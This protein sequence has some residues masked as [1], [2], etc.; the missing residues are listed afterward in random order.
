MDLGKKLKKYLLKPLGVVLPLVLA[1][2]APMLAAGEDGLLGRYIGF[3]KD[4][5]EKTVDM[6]NLEKNLIKGALASTDKYSYFQEIET[7][8]SQVEEYE[9]A[10]FVGIGITMTQEKRGAYVNSV[11]R[12]SP[13]YRAGIK[14]GDVIVSAD[15]KEL[16]GMPIADIAKL[17][18][19]P[20][21]TTVEL[22]Y[23]IGGMGE[24]EYITVER[25]N[26]AMT[27]VEYTIIEN[28]GYI[29][30]SGF[31][32]KTGEEFAAAL[33][34]IDKA[35]TEGLILDL[36]DNGGGT[37]KGCIETAAKLLSEETIVR[38]EFKYP[39]YLDLR[40]VAPENKKSRTAVVIVNENTASAAEILAAALHDN[41][42][43]ILVGEN[44]YGKSLV[45]SSFKILDRDAYARYAAMT[46]EKDMNVIIRRLAMTG[47]TP[48]DDEWLG[49]MKLT[50]GEYMT[51]SGESI[52]NTGIRPDIEIGY[53]GT[54]MIDRPSN[55]E[56][57]VHEK[58]SVGMASPEVGKARAILKQLGYVDT[59]SD[60]YDEAA[61]NAVMKF[62]ADE[63]LYPYGV[64]DYTTQRA[65]NNRLRMM[66]AGEKDPQVAAALAQ[67]AKEADNE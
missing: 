63:G 30:I 3:I 20:L 52:N 51:P 5:S 47:N 11:F 25:A 39:G 49:A 46:G 14:A 4:K 21:D 16:A 6:V 34:K 53:E 29:R 26:V 8:E 61:F 31:T 50:V 57:W 27:T 28:T 36:R 54:S 48:R 37:V 35:D 56:I 18:K 24:T 55:G 17:I 32:D 58:Y 44:T 40:Y 13:A 23:L 66:G 15:G 1:F 42:R 12:D 45:Q 9:E 64:L 62:Q 38:L 19:G 60:N 22:G 43:G 65:L 59:V 2:S 10:N 7:Y 67:I 33:E 41:G